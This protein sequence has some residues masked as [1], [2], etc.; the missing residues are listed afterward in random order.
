MKRLIALFLSIAGLTTIG[1]AQNNMCN[2]SD[3]FCTGTTY[4]FPAGVNAG[5]AETGPSYGCLGSE[6]NPAWYYLLIDQPGNISIEMHT[7]P[8]HD[9]DFACWGPFTSQTGPCTAQLTGTGSTHH[10]AGAGGGYPSGNMID[11]SYDAS[12]QEWVYIPNAQ[13]GQYYILLITNY[14]NQACNIIFSQINN[15]QTGAGTTNCNIVACFF[16]NITYTVNPC[17]PLTNQYSVSGNLLFHFTPANYAMTGTLTI[18]DQPSGISQTFNAPFTSPTA[19]NLAGILSDGASHTLTAT[20]SDAATC[21]YTVTYTAPTSCNQCFANAGSNVTVCGLNATVSATELGTDINTHWLPQANISYG[22]INSPTTSV[23]ATVP[24]TYNLVWQ[25]TN[26]SNLTCTDTVQVIFNAVPTSTFNAPSPICAGQTST[27]TYTGTN[28]NQFNWN[29]GTGGNPA[30]AV[31]VGPHTITYA[32]PGSNTVSLW[33]TAANGCTSDTTTHVVTVN[34]IP[35]SAFVAQSPVCV[36]NPSYVAYSTPCDPNYSYTW[37]WS[38]GVSTPGTGCGPHSVVW[39]T[40]GLQSIYLTVT[41]TVTGC[42][43]VPTL[44]QV[45]VLAASTPN[46]CFTPNP[47]AGPDAS[48]CSFTTSLSA[49]L[50]SPGNVASWSQVSGPGTSMFG[51]GSSNNSTVTVTAPGCYTFAWHE[52]SGACD[53]TDNVIICFTEQPRANAGEKGQICGSDYTMAAVPS[54]AGATGLWS[55]AFGLSATFTPVSSPNANAHANSGYGTYYFIWTETNGTC[56][57]SDTVR[58]DFLAIPSVSAGVDATSC[59]QTCVLSA[60][61]I[62]PGYWTSSVAAIYTANSADPSPHVWIPTYTPTTYPVTFTWHAFN[63]ICP[64]N[65]AVTITFIKPPHAEAGP[66]QSICGSTSQMAADTIGSGIVNAWWTCPSVPGMVI[67]PTGL[68]PIPW[69]PNVDAT[70]L[71]TN[72]F[73]PNSQHAVWFYWNAQNGASCNSVDSVLVTFYQKPAANAGIDTAICGKSYDLGGAWSITNHSGIWSTQTNSVPPPPGTANFVPTTTPDAIVT[74]TDYGVYNFIWKEMNQASTVCFDRDTVRIEFKTVPMPD[75]GLDF[76]V[77]GKFAYICATTSVPGGQWSCPSGGVAYY[78]AEN[79]NLTPANQNVPCTWI[80]YSSENDTVTMYWFE[81]NGSCTGYDS[82][83]VYFSSIQTATQLVDPA[84][85][86]VCGPVFTLLNAQQ[87][88]YGSGYWM[89]TVQNTTFTPTPTNPSPVATIDTGG[90][91]YYGY[92]HFYWITVNGMC[93][94]TSEVV[95][96]KFIEMPVANAGPNYWSGLFGNN[97]RIKT[98]TVC[99]LNYEMGAVPSIG[100]G[101]WYSLDPTNVHFHNSTGPQQ[102]TIYNDSLYITGTSYTVFN[103]TGPKYREFIWQ[104]NHEGCVN[105]D[106]LR[107]YFAPHP[108]GTFTT[109]MPACRHDS[110]MIIANTWPLPGHVDYMITNYEWA[111][112]NGNLSPVILNTTVSDTIYVSWPTG[113]QHNVTLITTNTWGCRSGI[114]TNQVVEPAPFNPSYNLTNAHCMECN[115]EILLS[116]A[117]GAQTNYYTFNWTDT[118]FINPSALLQTQL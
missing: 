26:S 89:D 40:V 114:V 57:S 52:I 113:E 61:S 92:H 49:S 16:D 8:Q 102:T 7:V 11:C 2:L 76:S 81:N 91:D 67:T 86:V 84:D 25:V 90:V 41:N 82:V 29:F 83:N 103:A 31:S 118:A 34:S 110:S 3:P 33:V 50:P 27:M 63:G 106:T 72:F 60:D 104:E 115:G 23:I 66:T 105:S 17:N 98:D 37:D 4:N 108:S 59:G 117:N 80:R 47:N 46:C 85:S 38:G 68:D 56:T 73:N 88:A 107:L 94:D 79:G 97:H 24:G 32:T 1:F 93:R 48:V 78:D 112:T 53:S 65:D 22:S 18:V 116:T 70:L 19:F 111:Y 13:T 96:V 95:P 12:W 9:V 100:D 45:D 43:S 71:G 51:S 75:A 20:F 55:T 58:V 101:H 35:S 39:S 62:Y 5:T 64:G 6:P 15:G 44:Q 69:N 10:A 77:C 87:P 74:V 21:T 36:N 14:S 28:G 99:G 54:V 109:T 30:T 42:V